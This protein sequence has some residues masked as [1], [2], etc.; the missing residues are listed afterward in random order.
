MAF[1]VMEILNAS[2]N[3]QRLPSMWKTAD[4]T[5]LPKKKPVHFLEKDLHPISLTPAVKVAEGFIVDDYVK[6]AVLKD[7]QLLRH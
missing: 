4:V 7:T 1:P 3:K 5:P 2:F 6:P